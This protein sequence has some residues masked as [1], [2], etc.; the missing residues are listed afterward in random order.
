MHGHCR[1]CAETQSNRHCGCAE[2]QS[3]R[4]CGCAKIQGGDP[5]T[6]P[7]CQ[8]T[9]D[10]SRYR[11]LECAARRHAG[12]NGAALSDRARADRNSARYRGIF[13]AESAI[14]PRRVCWKVDCQV[15]GH[16]GRGHHGNLGRDHLLRSN[17]TRSRPREAICSGSQGV[18]HQGRRGVPPSR[19]GPGKGSGSRKHHCLPICH[20][21]RRCQPGRGRTAAASSATDC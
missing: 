13:R 14:Q 11:A 9:G 17:N 5:S 12:A 15:S 21:A 10:P 19:M 20:R 2:I 7:A 8:S 1:G 16:T 6:S 4:R 3:N 18:H